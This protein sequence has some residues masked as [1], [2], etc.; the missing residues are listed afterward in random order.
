MPIFVKGQEINTKKLAEEFEARKKVRPKYTLNTKPREK[1]DE[2]YANA[3]IVIGGEEKSLSKSSNF[4]LDMISNET[5]N[6]E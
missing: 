6:E 5:T 1:T 3:K 4:M 2:D